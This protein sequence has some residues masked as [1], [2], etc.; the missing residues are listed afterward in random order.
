[1]NSIQKLTLSID[2]PGCQ[3]ELVAKQGDTCRSMEITLESGGTQYV[4]AEGET[5]RFRQVKPD[6]NMVYNDCTVSADRKTLTVDMTA[7]VTACVGTSCC[8]IVLYDSAEKVLSTFN[9]KLRVEPAPIGA[10]ADSQNESTF[11]DGMVKRAE[12]AADGAENARQAI[13]NMTVSSETLAAGSEATVQKSQNPDGTVNL[14]FGIPKGQ[15]GSGGGGTSDHRE[16]SH[17]DAEN[18]HPMSAITGLTAKLAE[19]AEKTEIP[20]V[21]EWAMKPNKPT[22]TAEEVNALPDTTVIPTKT[23]ELTNDSGFITGEEFPTSTASDA[24]KFLRV[25]ASGKAEWQTVASANG[26]DF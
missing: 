4:L 20:D 7:Q 1:M 3:G 21:P 5:A 24:G 17:R 26:V 11:F 6:G 2:K 23:S 15:D 13:E 10:E 16:L 19:K 18:Q 25:N 9:F 14:A 8:D 12:D 22:Y